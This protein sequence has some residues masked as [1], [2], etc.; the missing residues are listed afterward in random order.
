[1]K[2]SSS[3]EDNSNKINQISVDSLDRNLSKYAEDISNEYLVDIDF[4][5]NDIKSVSI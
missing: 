1:M 3:A 5:E 2:S 4:K